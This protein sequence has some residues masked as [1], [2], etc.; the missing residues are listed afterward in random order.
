MR[1]RLN[2]P[3][4]ASVPTG[5]SDQ[6][7]EFGARDAGSSG[8]LPAYGPTDLELIERVRSGDVDAYE[9]LVR[10]YQ[11]RVFA[12]VQRMLGSQPSLGS[13][14]EAADLTQEV[15]V[16]VYQTLPRYRAQASFQTWLYR[17]TANLCV[18]RYRRRQRTPVVARS[19]DAPLETDSGEVELEVPDWG[20][21]PSHRLQSAELRREVH[22]ALEV[23]SDKLRAVI[24]MHDLEGLSYEEVAEALRIPLGT[25]KSRLFHARAALK[26]Q[27]EP[28][29]GQGSP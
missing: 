18:D 28:Y 20:S 22:R 29:L 5:E 9:H 17:V 23:L 13:M 26:A 6:R 4:S 7:D 3:A 14:E 21:E 2:H 25:V 10:R 8:E 19:L 12:H 27:L 16:K 24:V 15:F 1:F 11:P